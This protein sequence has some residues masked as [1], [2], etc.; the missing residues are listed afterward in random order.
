MLASSRQFKSTK[1]VD[2]ISDSFAMWL[3]LRT[4]AD[5]AS[6]PVLIDF[7]IDPEFSAQG[8]FQ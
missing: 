8:R 6:D 3:S 5:V 2:V 1:D 7:A 4:V